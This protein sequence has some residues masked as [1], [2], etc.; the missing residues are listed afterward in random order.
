MQILGS[1]NSAYLKAKKW[2]ASLVYW[3]RVNLQ[4]LENA[5]ELKQH[6]RASFGVFSHIG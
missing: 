3:I 6:R 5:E 2:E 4:T 1:E